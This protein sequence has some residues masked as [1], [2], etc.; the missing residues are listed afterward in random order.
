AIVSFDR[1]KALYIF[2][3]VGFHQIFLKASS[4]SIQLS[5]HLPYETVDHGVEMMMGMSL[6]SGYLSSAT[7]KDVSWS[8]HMRKKVARLIPPYIAALAVTGLSAAMTC[9]TTTCAA[10]LALDCLTLGGWNPMLIWWTSNRPLW[11]ISTLLTYHYVSP[12]FLAWIRR[13]SLRQLWASLIGMY[14]FRL[15]LAC[16]VLTTLSQIAADGQAS[17]EWFRIIHVWSPTQIWIPFM[18]AILEQLV[19]RLVIPAWIQRWHVWL[20]SRAELRITG[21]FLLALVSLMSCDCNTC[22]ADNVFQKV[23]SLTGGS[24]QL[25][26]FMLKI[27]YT[28]YLTH[29]PFASILHACGVF[30]E[31]SWNGMAGTWA[32]S[33]VFAI[34]FD[35]LVAEPF[36]ELFSSWLNPKAKSAKSK[37]GHVKK[38]NARAESD[39]NGKVTDT[40]K[41]PSPKIEQAMSVASPK[42]VAS[43]SLDSVDSAHSADSADS[44]CIYLDILSP[45]RSFM[46]WS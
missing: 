33:V 29:W 39:K 35:V 21:P 34:G 45:V 4:R 5:E 32:G 8:E 40:S 12:F 27:S 2:I 46:P 20:A 16:A 41:E 25:C 17:K 37:E 31:D 36:T 1:T 15:S 24:R 18:G 43:T 7:W 42:S 13:R 19:S 10:Q 6:I 11:F 44:G 3:L 14:V 38:G 28:L 22:R 23:T 9:R 26:G 30:D